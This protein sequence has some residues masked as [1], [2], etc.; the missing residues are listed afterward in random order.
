M[1]SR[2]LIISLGITLIAV[3]MLFLYFR[4]RIGKIEQKVNLMFQLIQEHNT[5]RELEGRQRAGRTQNGAASAFQS[6]PPQAPSGSSNHGLIEISDD[7]G[8]DNKHTLAGD[9]DSSDAEPDSDS[10][11]VSDSDD[12]EADIIKIGSSDNSLGAIRTISLSLNGAEVSPNDH[13]VDELD[14]LSDLEEMPADIPV[15]SNVV[16][17]LQ[18]AEAMLETIAGENEEVEAE[19]AEQTSVDKIENAVKAI[20]VDEKPKSM[21]KMKVSELKDLAEARGLTNFRNLRKP[22]LLEL[23]QSSS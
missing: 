1:I 4:N 13:Q 18:G 22:K 10:E 11:E 15:Q 9:C 12:D 16:Q 20:T 14:E 3:A 5:S 19:D 21:D 6:A 2:G 8:P 17:L 7:E 23:L